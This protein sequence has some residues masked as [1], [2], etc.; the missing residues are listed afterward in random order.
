MITNLLKVKYCSWFDLS[1]NT[2]STVQKI[3]NRE[4]NTSKHL[5][6]AS[7]FLSY[8]AVFL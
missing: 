1:C 2:N 4:T 7:E 6:I 5:I 8:G 3:Q